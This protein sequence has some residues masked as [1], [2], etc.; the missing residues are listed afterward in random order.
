MT[1]YPALMQ[2]IRSFGYTYGKDGQTELSPPFD[3]GP[4]GVD[5]HL[6]G[7]ICQLRARAV[8]GI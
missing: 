7:A 6:V 5:L 8:H 2:P 4:Y 3:I 1:E